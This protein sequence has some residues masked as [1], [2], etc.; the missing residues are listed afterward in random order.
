VAAGCGSDSGSSSQQATP[1]AQTTKA[2]PNLGGPAPA[3]LLG[4]FT[5]TLTRRDAAGARKPDEL[6]IGPWT[7]VIG[8]SGGP[9]NSRALGIGNGDTNRVVYQFGVQGQTIALRCT[10]DQGIPTSGQEKF[11]FAVNGPKV[12]FKLT[13]AECAHAD[14]NLATILASHPWKKR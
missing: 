8:N 14:A 3:D 9:G 5:T 6:P 2:K 12:T 7:L 4:T 13:S 10:D 11:A 1:A